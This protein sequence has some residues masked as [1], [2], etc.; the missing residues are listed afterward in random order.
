MGD[1]CPPWLGL[2][3]HP[4]SGEGLSRGRIG[5]PTWGHGGRGLFQRKESSE[6]PPPALRLSPSAHSC[7]P[8]PPREGLT[9]GQPSGKGFDTRWH[10]WLARGLVLGPSPPCHPSREGRRL[11]WFRAWRSFLPPSCLGSCFPSMFSAQQEGIMRFACSAGGAII[12][13]VLAIKGGVWL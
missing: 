8:P 12:W 6:P 2:C 7:L 4:Q 10:T 3:A 13:C 11:P 1:C 9:I 5:G